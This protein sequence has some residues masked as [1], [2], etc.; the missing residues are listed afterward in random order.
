MKFGDNCLK[1]WAIFHTDPE[2]SIMIQNNLQ[3]AQATL[4]PIQLSIPSI[5][6]HT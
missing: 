5:E 4:K 2:Y 1:R 6:H 3:M